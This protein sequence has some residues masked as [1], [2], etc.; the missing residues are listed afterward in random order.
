M[1]P[2][3]DYLLYVRQQQ[4][5]H[6]AQQWRAAAPVHAAIRGRRR[7]RFRRAFAFMGWLSPAATEK[8]H[9]RITL[10]ADL[11][12]RDGIDRADGADGVTSVEPDHRIDREQQLCRA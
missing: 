1:N 2:Q 5:H 6:A 8:P 10:P 7:A 11:R 12:I 4:L 3:L 9:R